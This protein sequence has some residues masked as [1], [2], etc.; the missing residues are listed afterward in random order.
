MPGEVITVYAGQQPPESGTPA[1]SWEGL[2]RPNASSR[3]WQPEVIALL[4][5]RWTIDGRLVSSFL[6]RRPPAMARW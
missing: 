5:E 3:P 1:C 6:N 4:R 2:R